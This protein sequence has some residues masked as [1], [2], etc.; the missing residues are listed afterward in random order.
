MIYTSRKRCFLKNVRPP[1][2]NVNS[3]LNSE[4]QNTS[5]FCIYCNFLQPPSKSQQPIME[6]KHHAL[7]RA[8]NGAYP[9]TTKAKHTL[10]SGESERLRRT[11]RK[12]LPIT[13]SLP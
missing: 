3:I 12:L 5:T 6:I 4:N 10:K 1:K 8:A 13:S 9:P 7:R 2:K 11:R